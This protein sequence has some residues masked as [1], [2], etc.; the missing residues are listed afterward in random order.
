VLT[1]V[2]RADNLPARG[3][4]ITPPIQRELAFWPG[5]PWNGRSGG[6]TPR[7]SWPAVFVKMTPR[8]QDSV[9]VPFRSKRRETIA[10]SQRNPALKASAQSM[11]YE[12]SGTL[13]GP[14]LAIFSATRRL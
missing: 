14:A 6:A 7:A 4:D 9:A 3:I 8:R 11:G 5:L 13:A 10:V 12:P 1:V 2:V